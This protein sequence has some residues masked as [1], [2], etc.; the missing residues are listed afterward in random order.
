M[1]ELSCVQQKLPK[2]DVYCLCFLYEGLVWYSSLGLNIAMVAMQDNICSIQYI[3]CGLMRSFIGTE[4]SCWLTLE[5]QSCG[6]SIYS[7]VLFFN[8]CF[9]EKLLQQSSLILNLP[10]R[11]IL[12][13]LVEFQYTGEWAALCY[14]FVGKNVVCSIFLL[15]RQDCNS[16]RSQSWVWHVVIHFKYFTE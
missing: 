11:T 10:L 7:L 4:N 16:P 13:F 6:N 3:I 5:T 1:P 12:P 15:N 2:K 8:L 9:S 14:I